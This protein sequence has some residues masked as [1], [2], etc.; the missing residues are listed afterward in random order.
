ML[1]CVPW[2]QKHQAM[3]N[4]VLNLY[5]AD[6]QIELDNVV[7]FDSDIVRREPDLYD[8]INSNS[9]CG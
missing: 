6:L 2:L 7:L 1:T 8:S 4:I 9:N 3:S 5:R